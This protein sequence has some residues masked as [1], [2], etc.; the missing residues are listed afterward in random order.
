MARRKD[1]KVKIEKKLV[2]TVGEKEN[3]YHRVDASMSDML[4]LHQL[5]QRQR[6]RED[7]RLFGKTELKDI[8]R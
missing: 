2:D 1:M 7:A 4:V 3:F 5:Q 8:L 6:Q